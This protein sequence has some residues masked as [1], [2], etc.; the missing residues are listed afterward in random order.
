MLWTYLTMGKRPPL[1]PSPTNAC[2]F[3]ASLQRNVEDD[4]SDDGNVARGFVSKGQG[5]Q[6]GG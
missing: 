6:L 2:Q 5:R 4:V 3:F 1:S